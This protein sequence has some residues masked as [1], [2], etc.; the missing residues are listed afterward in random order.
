[1]SG[2]L[3][4]AGRTVWQLSFEASPIILVDGLAAALGVG[5]MLPIIALTEPISVVNGI[6]TGN[7]PASL[8]N[9]FARFMPMPGSMLINQQIGL[10]PFAN[11]QVAANA[12]IEQPLPISMLMYAPVNTTG[13]YVTKIATFT[14]LQ[15]ALKQHNL[16]G[17]TYTICTPSFIFTNCVMTGM[18]DVTGGEGKQVQTT[19]QLDFIRPLITLQAASQALNGLMGQ[20]SKFLPIIGNPSYSGASAGSVPSILG[21]NVNG[22]L[23]GAGSAVSSSPLAPLQ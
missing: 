14:L 1:M 17:G 22:S 5:G 12:V 6:L 21:M 7:F 4:S 23:T 3:N 20:M 10:Y 18:T 8:D 11:Q 19:W 13:G 15:A 2:I 9:L 16:S